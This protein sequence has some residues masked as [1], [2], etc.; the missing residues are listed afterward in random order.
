M[1]IW[2]EVYDLRQDIR[3]RIENELNL[4]PMRY[5]EKVVELLEAIDEDLS[6]ILREWD[7][8]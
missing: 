7:E 5:D 6:N 4:D 3:D 8:K 2:R 1:T